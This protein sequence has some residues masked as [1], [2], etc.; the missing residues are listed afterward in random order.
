LGESYRVQFI[1]MIA[2]DLGET[3]GLIIVKIQTSWKDALGK[4]S[5]LTNRAGLFT[6]E[7]EMPRPDREGDW[8]PPSTWRRVAEVLPKDYTVHSLYPEG[9]EE[10]A[11]PD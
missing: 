6:I 2:G 4:L 1:G 7:L 3:D 9:G 8:I 5:M 10:D 11:E